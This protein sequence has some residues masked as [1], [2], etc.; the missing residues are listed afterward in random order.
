MKALPLQ[1]I[2][3]SIRSYLLEQFLFS[4]LLIALI[5][6]VVIILLMP[7]AE[8]YLLEQTDQWKVEKVGGISFYSDLD[9]DGESEY[10]IEF[11][12]RAGNKALK[13][14]TQKGIL[15]DQYNFDGFAIPKSPQG[16]TFTADY[17][18]NGFKEIYSC[19]WRND[20][21]FVD[22]FSPLDPRG[23]ERK[24][25]FLDVISNYSYERDFN[26]GLDFPH[27]F[28]KDGFDELLFSIH[29]GFSLQPRNLYL[30]NRQKQSLIKSPPAGVN[31]SPYFL[32]D[33]NGDGKDELMGSTTTVGNIAPDQPI[34]YRDSSSYVMVLTADMR[35]LFEPIEFT[36]YPSSTSCIPFI[37]ESDTLILCLFFD[38]SNKY[39]GSKL[40]LLNT[41][42][43]Q[44]DSRPLPEASEHYEANMFYSDQRKVIIYFNGS[45]STTVY[46][47]GNDL[48]L[49][50]LKTFGYF[51]SQYKFDMDEDGQKE[52]VL[53]SDVKQELSVVRSD[54]SHQVTI[55]LPYVETTVF[56]VSLQLNGKQPPKIFSQYGPVCL[57]YQYNKNPAY[58][59][60]F[61]VHVGVFLLMWL[62]MKLLQYLYKY[63]IV[64]QQ[65]LQHELTQLQYQTISHQLDPH[66]ILNAMNSLTAS[67][68]AQN[69][70]DAYT[71]AAKFSRLF[72]D[73]L[74][75]SDQVSRP[76]ADE[77]S[78]VENY[79]QLEQKRFNN[80]FDFQ[81]QLDAAVDTETEVPKMLIQNFAEN[82]VKHG[83]RHLTEGGLLSIE[84]RQSDKHML[85][86]ITDNGIG[87][88]KARALQT[89]GTEKGLKLMQQMASLYKK[90][91]GVSI[92]IN[93][94]DL[95]NEKGEAAGTQVLVDLDLVANG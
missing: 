41:K 34:P 36:V 38:K 64:R 75:S 67:I 25:F 62:L 31:F 84:I 33:I 15:I 23:M 8:P 54:F 28:D 21:V 49:N 40:V 44:L 42:G 46:E 52:F 68:M 78:F 45:E 71:L 88:E 58:A 37:R 93:I 56:K 90:L 69:K 30:F 55:G 32:F 19:Y 12:N 91:K 80:S 22:Y 3:R 86:N 83:L 95:K 16:T 66:F 73:T 65:K 76:L 39:N 7:K 85:I 63:Q 9:G 79:L 18:H 60:R 26:V 20:S 10:L 14:K 57:L 6:S 59:Y 13:I 4:P 50:H 87:R 61:L 35:F 53:Y 27:D 72:R 47:M 81:I 17:D 94:T 43:E 74:T 82:A 51:Y 48:K 77:L 70:E 24:I 2:W 11:T 89:N 1:H 92:H 29:A 5:L